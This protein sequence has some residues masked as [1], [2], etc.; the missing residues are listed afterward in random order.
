MGSD[1]VGTLLPTPSAWGPQVAGAV[2]VVL[3]SAFPE[4]PRNTMISI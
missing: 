3:S 4:G 2:K 1:V